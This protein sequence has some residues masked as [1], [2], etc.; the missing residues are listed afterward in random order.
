VS[1]ND[2]ASH[3]E[4]VYEV[5]RLTRATGRRKYARLGAHP[6]MREALASVYFRRLPGLY[7]VLQVQGR[8]RQRLVTLA[9]PVPARN[10]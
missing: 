1:T 5:H 7:R 8:R 2:T 3:T 10:P 4:A 9:C 6:S